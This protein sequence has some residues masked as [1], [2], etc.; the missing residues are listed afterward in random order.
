M[1]TSKIL[2]TGGSTKFPNFKERYE[3]DLRPLVPDMYRMNVRTDVS[4]YL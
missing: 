2:L 3:Q 1:A 4:I